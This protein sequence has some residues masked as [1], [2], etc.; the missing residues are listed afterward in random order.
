MNK[1]SKKPT[2]M[3]LLRKHQSLEAAKL[4]KKHRDPTA[5]WIVVDGRVLDVTGYL[6]RH[7]GGATCIA[8]VIF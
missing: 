8:K 7:P 3:D 2:P 5:C 6:G 4:I 1:A